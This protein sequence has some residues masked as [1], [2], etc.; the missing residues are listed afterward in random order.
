MVDIPANS[1]TTA[2]FEG[3]FGNTSLPAFATFSGQ[4]EV[5]GDRDWIKVELKQGVI[6][7]FF[8]HFENIVVPA[9]GGDSMLRIYNSNGT[10]V[11]SNNDR[12][13]GDQNSFVSFVAPSTGTYFVEASEFGDDRAGNYSILFME[14]DGS[15]NYILD[16][17]D[18]TYTGLAGQRILAGRGDDT[19]TL[20]EA[21]YAFGEQGKDTITGNNLV[22]YIS[23]GLGDD[24]INGGGEKDW[25]FGDAG[26]D[27]SSAGAVPT[28]FGADRA[29]I[30]SLVA[31][32]AIS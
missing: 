16:S 3:I 10:V 11:A 17:A 24:I 6:Y 22:N 4:L 19:I 8:M 9:S 21:N 12:A 5:S 7:E 1:T 28:S 31:M 2:M 30:R 32:R 26:N 25:L 14:S 23:G 13:D 20:G 27:P 29:T 18:N 15:A